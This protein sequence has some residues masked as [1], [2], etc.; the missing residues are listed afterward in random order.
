MEQ[1]IGRAV[2]FKSHINLPLSERKVDVY[3][4][5]L[6]TPKNADIPSGD[7]ILYGFIYEKQKQ[8]EDVIKIL[9]NASI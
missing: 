9:K 4:M 5:I 3:N 7:E 1:I 8:L 2:R 6:K